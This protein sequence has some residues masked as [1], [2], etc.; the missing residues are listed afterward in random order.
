MVA[1]KSGGVIHSKPYSWEGLSFFFQG[2]LEWL[3]RDVLR[4][5]GSALCVRLG[6]GR[7]ENAYT[8]SCLEKKGRVEF[9]SDGQGLSFP[10]DFLGCM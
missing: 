1:L 4:G 6:N 3:Q 8:V 7:W 9:K 2:L 10:E 5:C